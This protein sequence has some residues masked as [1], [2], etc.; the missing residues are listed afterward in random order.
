MTCE[1]SIPTLPAAASQ[2]WLVRFGS[3][4]F[5]VYASSEEEACG[6]V[7]DEF[8]VSSH[9][10]HA[11]LRPAELDPCTIEYGPGWWQKRQGNE[12]GRMG[13]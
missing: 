2:R 6:R 10:P 5:I 13:R 7:T 1:A 4:E 11:E 3:R 12:L 9:V 8:P